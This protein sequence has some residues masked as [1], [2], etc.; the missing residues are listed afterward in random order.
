MIYD[1]VLGEVIPE[2]HNHKF[3]VEAGKVYR[4]R[5]NKVLEDLIVME[6]EFDLE[7]LYEGVESNSDNPIDTSQPEEVE[8]VGCAGGACTL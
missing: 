6:D 3:T 8:D 1:K 2:E 5:D 7:N 4:V